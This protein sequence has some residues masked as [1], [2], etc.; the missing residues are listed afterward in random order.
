M[1]QISKA[2]AECITRSVDLAARY[3][4]EEFACIL[5][6]TDLHAAVSIAEKMRQKIQGLQIEHHRSPVSDYVTASF[7]VTTVEYTLDISLG[8]IIT[9][10]DRLL[11]KAKAAGRNRIEF[12]EFHG[13]LYGY[14][15]SSTSNS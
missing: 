3:G 1:R 10:A 6:D 7:G 15:K 14:E 5:P 4:G 13:H 2:L 12:A 9:V 11:Y 8:D